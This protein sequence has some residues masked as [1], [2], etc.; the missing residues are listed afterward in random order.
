MFSMVKKASP[1][2]SYISHRYVTELAASIARKVPFSTYNRC[3]GSVCCE[4]GQVIAKE[5]LKP[6]VTIRIIYGSRSHQ[7]ALQ[8]SASRYSDLASSALT[9]EPV[10]DFTDSLRFG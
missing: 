2:A 10:V 5:L 7:K 8:A 4:K 6:F 1:K 3:N 9:I